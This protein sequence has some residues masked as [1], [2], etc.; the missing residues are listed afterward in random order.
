MLTVMYNE[1]QIHLILAQ[2]FFTFDKCACSVLIMLLKV[3]NDS[4]DMPF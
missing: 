1:A 4:V 3:S 2:R